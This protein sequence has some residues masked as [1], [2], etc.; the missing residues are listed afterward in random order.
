MQDNLCHPERSVRHKTGGIRPDEFRQAV[1]R[2]GSTWILPA[3]G[4]ARQRRRWAQNDNIKSDLTKRWFRD[5]RFAETY[6]TAE[7]L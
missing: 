7:S 6:Q 1:W 5:E 4:E 3:A 2:K